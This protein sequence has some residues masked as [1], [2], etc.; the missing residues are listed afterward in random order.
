MMTA[1]QVLNREFLEIRAKI[2][3]LA[4]SF[5]RLERSEGSVT[6]DQRLERIHEALSVLGEGGGG[7][8]ER[9]QLIFSRS[10][11]EAWPEKYG[12]STRK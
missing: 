8:A 4:A 7:R 9:V 10:Y 12:L 11:E 2:L 5:D 3:E 1:Q 6:D